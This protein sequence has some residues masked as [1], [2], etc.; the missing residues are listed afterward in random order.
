MPAP[1]RIEVEGAGRTFEVKI[2]SG[3]DEFEQAFLLLAQKYQAKG[4]EDAG[5]KLFRFTPFHV[6]PETITV[7]ARDG[8][9]VV[10]TLSMVPDTALLGLPMESIYP[11]EVAR[12][13]REGRRL[14]EVTSL[15]DDGLGHREFL[16]VFEA[17]IRLVQ[18]YHLRIG[19]DT[20]LVTVN[21]RHAAFY[22]KVMGAVALRRSPDLSRRSR[23]APAEAY[24]ID[25]PDDEGERPEDVRPDL[26]RPPLPESVLTPPARPAD[27]VDFFGEHSTAADRRTIRDDRRGRRAPRGAR[28]DGGRPTETRRPRLVP[29]LPIARPRRPDPA[30]RKVR[31]PGSRTVRSADREPSIAR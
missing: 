23:D 16:A 19:G 27:H 21:P 28:P 17:M 13:R 3:S 30:R 8:A 11:E 15:A 5:A 20:W 29:G 24:L 10:A 9:R 7:V 26:R 12:L 14:A 18:Q 31:G 1:N 4:Y 25:L 2:A 6:L 22:R